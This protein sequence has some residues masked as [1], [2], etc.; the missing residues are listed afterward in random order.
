MIYSV[1]SKW[2]NGRLA[3]LVLRGAAVVAQKETLHEAERTM[4]QLRVAYDPWKAFQMAREARDDY[5]L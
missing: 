3:W 5:L 2:L 4:D 1:K